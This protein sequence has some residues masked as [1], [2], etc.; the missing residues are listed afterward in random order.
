MGKKDAKRLQD[1]VLAY[2][3]DEAAKDLKIDDP[4][5]RRPIPVIVEEA[6]KHFP[7]ETRRN[8]LRAAKAIRLI[9]GI[10]AVFNQ[11]SEKDPR[12]SEVHA[13]E[14][15]DAVMRLQK[16]M[17]EDAE[18]NQTALPPR[19]D[20]L[21]HSQALLLD[22]VSAAPDLPPIVNFP[23]TEEAPGGIEP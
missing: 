5:R 1:Q 19:T 22:M 6:T 7:G 21:L 17:K 11:K 15:V 14:V 18:E 10:K 16:K 3:L 13:V 23:I 8:V 12:I 9:A 4:V 20:G 2:V